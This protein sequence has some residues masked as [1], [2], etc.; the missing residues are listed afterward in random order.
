L[1][2]LDVL[3]ED[4]SDSGSGSS[5]GGDLEWLCR[6]LWAEYRIGSIDELSAA[7]A[8]ASAAASAALDASKAYEDKESSLDAPAAEPQQQQQQLPPLGVTPLLPSSLLG[9][10]VELV[11]TDVCAVCLT[12]IAKFTTKQ[13][14]AQANSSSSLTATASKQ[15]QQDLEWE[16]HVLQQL[17]PRIV[18]EMKAAGSSTNSTSRARRQQKK[19]HFPHMFPYVSYDVYSAAVASLLRAIDASRKA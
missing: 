2:L 9:V 14:A 10:E 12:D 3:R 18:E 13:L 19:S 6:K 15:E 17:V 8:A 1:T 7:A 5:S 16:Q 11:S 4:S